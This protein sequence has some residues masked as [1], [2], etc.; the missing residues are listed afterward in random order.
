MTTVGVFRPS[1]SPISHKSY[2]VQDSVI[3]KLPYVFPPF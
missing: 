1:G 3:T 2:L